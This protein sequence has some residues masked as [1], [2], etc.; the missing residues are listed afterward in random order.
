MRCVARR[1]AICSGLEWGTKISKWG[2]CE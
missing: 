2:T 1:A